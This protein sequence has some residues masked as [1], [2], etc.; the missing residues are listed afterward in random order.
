LRE[1]KHVQGAVFF[2]SKSLRD[3]LAGFNDSLQTDIYRYPTLP[4]TMPW[5]DNLNPNAPLLSEALATK[6]G[7]NLSWK[8]PSPAKDGD[9]ASGFVIYRFNEGESTNTARVRAI[10]KISFD[11]E[12]R[13]FVDETAEK[14][15]RYTYVITALDRIK[16]ESE[17]SNSV[18]VKAN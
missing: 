4:P 10:L 16:N 17:A 12:L 11:A 1:N 15:K 13:S 2:S 18:T 7:V 14:G 6:N 5:L 9:T 3:N 8:I